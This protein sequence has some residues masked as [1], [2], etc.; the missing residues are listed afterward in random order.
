MTANLTPAPQSIHLDEPSFH[1]LFHRYYTP[2]CLFGLQYL[3]DREAAADVVQEAFARLWQI[4][5]DFLFEHQVRSFLYMAVRNRC[6]NELEHR[7][8][9][10]DYADRVQQKRQEAFFRDA[11]V[12]QETYRLLAEAIDRLP[13][14]M[15]SVMLL[16]LE[17]KKN[18]EMAEELNCSVDT[19]KTL[20]R[21]A[22]QKLRV[23]LKDH[24]Y[25]LLL[26][27]LSLPS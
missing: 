15:R 5:R 19:V 27:G 1:A 26:L 12:E 2:L 25:C 6:L 7:R 20:R 24:Y 17:G 16:A 22:Y 13:P 9:V 11:L 10:T 14:R 4:R 18:A 8:V 21:L 23:M 3:E